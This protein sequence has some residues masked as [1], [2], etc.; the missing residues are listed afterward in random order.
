MYTSIWYF[1]MNL[2]KHFLNT[3][4]IHGLSFISNTRR[5]ARLF[6]IFVVFAGFTGAIILI[7]ESFNNWKQSPVSTTIETWPIEKITLPNV[8]ICP[9]KNSFLNLNYDILQ[10]EKQN[11]LQKTRH[12]LFDHALEVVQNRFYDEMM[13]NLSKVDWPDLFYNWYH[14]NT[15]IMYPYYS[16]KDNQLYFQILTTA[17]S[18]NISTNNFGEKFDAKKVDGNLLIVVSVYVPLAVQNDMN[19]TLFLKIEKITMKEHSQTDRLVLF[20]KTIIDAD[21]TSYTENIT[22]PFENMYK[23]Y[24][25]RLVKRE[26]IENIKLDK[27]PGFRL[28]WHYEPKVEMWPGFSNVIKNTEFVK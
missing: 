12:E 14:K 16:Q 4:T 8:T 11:L 17:S 5:Y 7:N 3:S 18:G 27:I 26:D 19:T 23:I 6:W 28:N 15:A 2:M 1:N 21:I 13:T 24:L 22:A 20:S 25:D 10:A 9:P